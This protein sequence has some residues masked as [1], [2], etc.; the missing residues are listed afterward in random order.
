MEAKR[1]EAKRMEAKRMEAKRM[2]AKRMEA[3]RMEAKRM[4]AKRMEVKTPVLTALHGL[5]VAFAWLRFIIFAL[6][7]QDDSL[8]PMRFALELRS[9]F[10]H[11]KKRRRHN[12]WSSPPIFIEDSGITSA[13]FLDYLFQ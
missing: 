3:K 8:A 11:I 6:I 10:V 13:T 12:V 9:F 4:E 5:T 2:E 1:M 7:C